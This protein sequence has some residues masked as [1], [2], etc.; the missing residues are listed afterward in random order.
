MTKLHNQFQQRIKGMTEEQIK[1]YVDK[2]VQ[3]YSVTPTQ[4]GN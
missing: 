4:D 1:V 2:Q 3:K